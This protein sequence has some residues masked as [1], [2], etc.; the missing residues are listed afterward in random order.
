M[1]LGWLR[2]KANE[3]LAEERP[4]F[5]M[6]I[7]ALRPDYRVGQIALTT[8]LAFSGWTRRFRYW[9]KYRK[10]LRALNHAKRVLRK[11]HRDNVVGP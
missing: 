1:L 3:Y 10:W 9:R 2:R 7:R 11:I 6:P 8:L 5:V 4:R